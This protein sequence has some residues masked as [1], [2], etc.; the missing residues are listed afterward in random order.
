MVAASSALGAA[1][2]LGSPGTLAAG[3]THL[4]KGLSQLTKY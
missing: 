3:L 2:V 4:G 1:T